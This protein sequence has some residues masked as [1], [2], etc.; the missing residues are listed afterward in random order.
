MRGEAET[1]ATGS[2]LFI[3]LKTE[4]FVALNTENF[5]SDFARETWWASTPTYETESFPS[6]Y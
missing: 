1:R 2:F 3:K 6:I 4:N 5:R